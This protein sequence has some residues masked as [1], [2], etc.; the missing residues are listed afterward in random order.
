[1][2]NYCGRVLLAPL[3]IRMRTN[4]K[5]MSYVWILGMPRYNWHMAFLRENR[6][7]AM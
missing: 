3:S 5:V 4:M 1:M 7:G 6:G 2:E